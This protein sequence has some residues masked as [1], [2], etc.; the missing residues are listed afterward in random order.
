MAVEMGVR[1]LHLGGYG[2]QFD[3]DAFSQR[4]VLRKIREY[5]VRSGL[6]VN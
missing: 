2:Y 3:G 5:K 4:P 1:V 6:S